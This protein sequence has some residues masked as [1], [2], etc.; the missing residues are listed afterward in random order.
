MDAPLVPKLFTQT[1]KELFTEAGL[2]YIDFETKLEN[3]QEVKTLDNVI[4]ELLD[5]G[6]VASALRL[7]ALFCHKNKAR[8]NEFII[9]I[10]KQS[11]LFSQDLRLL[12]TCLSLAESEIMPY[13]LSSEQRL[14]MEQTYTPSSSFR[15]RP[16]YS[17]KL[18][19]LASS[20]ISAF[21]LQFFTNNFYCFTQHLLAKD[22]IQTV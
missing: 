21:L 15:K 4:G 20:N 16:L 10:P 17:L 3:E 12:V 11:N 2:G 6:R 5:Q 19:S 8:N 1:R 13:Q 18:C 14:L 7:E 9:F 22:R